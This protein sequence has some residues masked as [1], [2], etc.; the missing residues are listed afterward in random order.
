MAGRAY[1]SGDCSGFAP[2]SLFI[3]LYRETKFACK[4]RKKT[5]FVNQTPF[6]VAVIR[7]KYPH[8]TCHVSFTGPSI[9]HSGGWHHNWTAKP[10]YQKIDMD[11]R[12]NSV[13][14]RFIDFLI[15][16]I[17]E[18]KLDVADGASSFLAS[19]IATGILVVVGFF[20]L[21]FLSF[22]MAYGLG[23]L[24]DNTF[25]GFLAVTVLYGLIAASVIAFKRKMIKVPLFHKLTDKLFPDKS[26]L[27][28]ED[29]RHVLEKHDGDEKHAEEKHTQEKHR[30]VS[31]REPKKEQSKAKGVT[32]SRKGF[33][34]LLKD[35][36]AGWNEADP[37]AQS[38]TVAYYAI[39]SLPAL[40]VLVISVAS[41]AFGTEEV[42]GKL[43]SD[44][45]STMGEDTAK[46]VKEMMEKAGEHD[47]SL[48]ASIIGGLTLI[49]G[50]TGVFGQL[51]KALNQVWEVKPKPKQAMLKMLKDRL[52][53]FGLVLSI[54]FLLL[55]SLVLTSMLT[56]FGD[57]LKG[58]LPDVA[59]YLLF[60]LNFVVSFV[61]ISVLFALMFKVLPDAKVI[62]KYVWVGAGIT[63]LLFMIGKFALGIYFGKA[64]PQ[65]AYGAAGSVILILL[66]VS[67]SCMI[68]FFGAEFTKQFAK[69]YGYGIQPAENAVRASH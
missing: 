43:F 63:G 12:K 65:S 66:W 48:W 23:Q 62:W 4:N 56:A 37:F 52:F 27:S 39:F 9:L 49:V 68:L 25:L 47:R 54:G 69:R 34:Q 8:R 67:Y 18:M 53:S 55:V 32:P 22:S 58:Q 38:A 44:I 51:Q 13:I 35:T 45:S 21:L 31:H 46:Q 5:G 17:K 15:R 16:K 11:S 1:S 64:E 28:D 6:L 20:I 7:E 59:V 10:G 29:V 33:F 19:V 2:D 26:E 14:A 42:S 40:L 41:F 61:I 60:V 30:P 24:M 36:F 57:W 3:L 50:A